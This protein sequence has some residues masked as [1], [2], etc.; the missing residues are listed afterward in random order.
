[1]R[2]SGATTA[3]PPSPSSAQRATGHKAINPGPVNVTDFLLG[4]ALSRAHW[5]YHPQLVLRADY[6]KNY[7]KWISNIDAVPEQW[8]LD[9][10]P[11]VFALAQ[12]FE[13]VRPR[14]R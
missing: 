12:G 5:K 10:L 3:S 8:Q 11:E 14:A 1:M 4:Y 7:N 9:A 2:C 13:T 6:D